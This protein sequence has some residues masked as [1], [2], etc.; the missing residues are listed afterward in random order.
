MVIVGLTIIAVVVFV[1]LGFI[2]RSH[3]RDSAATLV[4]GIGAIVVPAA[5]AALWLTNRRP[6]TELTEPALR[7]FADELAER[8]KAQWSAAASERRLI[9]PS[10][11]PVRWRWSTLPVS[12]PATDAVGTGTGSSRFRPLPGLAPI[13]AAD[14]ESGAVRDL[15][16]LYGALDSGRMVIVG[17]G[18]AGKSGAAIRLLLD[19]LS[20]REA[21][22]PEARA[23]VPVPVLLTLSGWD[24]LNQRLHDWL[25]TRLT[26]DYMF[27]KSED[28]AGGVVSR[29][30]GTGRIA[31]FLDGLDEIPEAVR[32]AALRALNE[33]T[34][35]RLVLLSRVGELVTAVAA[36]GPLSGSAGL[37]LLPVSAQDAAEYLTRCQAQ[38]PPE[39]WRSLVRHIRMNP[40]GAVAEALDTPLMLTLMRDT[41]RGDQRFDPERFA[42]RAAVEDHLLDRVLPAAY[43]DDRPGQPRSRYSL[44]QAERWLGV[45]AHQM[46]SEGSRDLAWWQVPRWRPAWPRTAASCLLLGFLAGAAG[47]FW[48][49]PAA[50]LGASAVVGLSVTTSL[51]YGRAGDSPQL[52]GRLQWRDFVVRENFVFGIAGGG[53]VGVA[54][55]VALLL[56]HHRVVMLFGGLVIGLLAG[57]VGGFVTGLSNRSAD[58]RTPIGPVSCWRQDRHYTL[59]AGIAGGLAGSLIGGACLGLLAELANE[60]IFG[61]IDG[62]L[63]GIA[64]VTVGGLLLSV[65]LSLVGSATWRTFLA[66][67]QL[68]MR[69]EAPIRLVRFLSDAHERHVLRAVGPVYQ[70]RHAR[71]QDRLEEAFTTRNGPRADA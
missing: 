50:G 63:S 27:R 1:V 52:L 67:L 62:F 60:R 68:R 5:S 31:V 11:V 53:A 47:L 70:F 19:A 4:Q 37:E 71:L 22:E 34:N 66:S 55:G 38:P 15:F 41:Y 35:F 61:V 13:T 51:T 12:G 54:I 9:H 10:P 44:G 69:N 20:H 7:D 48:A 42:D 56:T 36:E 2:F 17:A 33:Q 39:A 25:A 43:N 24:P 23:R 18:G 16:R 46:N 58:N 59:T 6:R 30:I 64:L 29:L 28:H 32:P 8:V 45:I 65:A 21:L 49:G 57:V 14:L 40:S 3:D 26:T